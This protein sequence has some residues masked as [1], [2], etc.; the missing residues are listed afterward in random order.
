MLL[1]NSDIISVYLQNMLHTNDFV[2]FR[3]TKHENMPVFTLPEMK[4]FKKHA[5]ENLIKDLKTEMQTDRQKWEA[6]KQM[7]LDFDPST[8]T[9]ENFEQIKAFRGSKSPHRICE[10]MRYVIVAESY[11]KMRLRCVNM[12]MTQA[13]RADIQHLVVTMHHDLISMDGARTRALCT[14]FEKLTAF[15]KL[16][17]NQYQVNNYH[18]YMIFS[19]KMDYKTLIS[20]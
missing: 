11:L 7:I 3:K 4:A 17:D 15:R 12:V 16:G 5:I 20:S 19:I 8:E 13:D 14:K 9:A 2:M 6:A 18:R 10:R 1:L